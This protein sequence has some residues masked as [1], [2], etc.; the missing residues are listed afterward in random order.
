MAGRLGQ[1]STGCLSVC[2]LTA[3]FVRY[4]KA[5][6]VTLRPVPS[7]GRHIGGCYNV[8]VDHTIGC[9]G[10]VCCACVCVW[11]MRLCVLYVCMCVPLC[12]RVLY[13]VVLS[14]VDQLRV[15]SRAV[16]TKVTGTPNV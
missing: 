13:E 3:P 2:S 10:C 15:V 9:M 4:I 11:Y 1:E 14:D 7:V 12:D 5:L 6:Y 8:F 16:V